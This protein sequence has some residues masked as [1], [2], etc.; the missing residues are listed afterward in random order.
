MLGFCLLAAKGFWL[1]TAKS[2][3]L[4]TAK[5]HFLLVT[6]GIFMLGSKIITVAEKHSPNGCITLFDSTL[7]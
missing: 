6:R 4:L 7:I 3:W 5:G 2:F 1:L